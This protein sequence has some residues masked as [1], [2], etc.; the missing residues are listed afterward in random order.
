MNNLFQKHTHIAQLSAKGMSL[1][2]LFPV[3]MVPRV[4][5]VEDSDCLA[6]NCPIIPNP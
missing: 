4:E 1:P 3:W 5:S 6:I 2:A